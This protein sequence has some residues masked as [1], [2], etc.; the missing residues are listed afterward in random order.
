MSIVIRNAYVVT[1]NKSRDIIKG[2]IL[3]DNGRIIHVGN[4]RESGDIE[5]DATG[6]V[7]IPGLINTHS[8]V[9]MSLLKGQIDDL[10]FDKF[11][12]KS[13]DID[14][15]RTK[16][17]ILAG[18]RQGCMEML[19]TGTTTFVDLY[20]SQDVIARSVEETGIRG[21]LGW[22]ILDTQ[23]TTQ[24]G[25][26]LDNAKRFHRDY[27][28]HARIM[29][30][31]GLQGVYVC[32]TE[33]FLG[34]KEYALENDLLMTFHLSETRKE[35]ADCKKKEGR[36]PA[37][38]LASIDF[39]NDHCL[40]A[41]SAWLTIN[42]IKQLAQNGVKVS[43]CPASNMKLATGGVAP[44]PEMLQHNVT[45]SIGTDGST[46]NNCLDMFREMRLLSLLQKSNRWDPTI[47]PA[48]QTLD[49]AT[50]GGAKAIRMDDQLGSIEAGKRADVVIMNGKSPN[51]RPMRIENIVSNIIY[52]ACGADVKTVL[53][54]G[55]IVVKDRRMTTVDEEKILA[56]SE[57]AVRK[58]LS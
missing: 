6:D 7:I 47:L 39:L 8:H 26:P 3:I 55:K 5:I 45:V 22:A 31:L 34:A 21:V 1:Q 54:D 23:Y 24:S 43:T 11:L 41:H 38:Y 33:T 16:V 12:D 10:T 57:E 58:L 53:C 14:A 44:I 46:T 19:L 9:S 56:D 50:I 36:R 13:F 35:V 32:S 37:D 25:T 4:V 28:K 27:K 17:D 49:M 48:Q 52:S 30:A 18:A 15:K 20:Y 42:E 2:D 51:L 29:P 40:A